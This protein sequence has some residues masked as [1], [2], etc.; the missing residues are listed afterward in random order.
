MPPEPAA[1]PAVAV[2]DSAAPAAEAPVVEPPVLAAPVPA[3]PPAPQLPAEPP[4]A[5]VAEP[6]PA[7]APAPAPQPPMAVAAVPPLAVTPPAPIAAPDVIPDAFV[8]EASRTAEGSLRLS[9]SVPDEATRVALADLAAVDGLTLRPDLPGDFAAGAQAGLAALGRIVEGR[10]GFADGVWAL[11][12]EAA[13]SADRYALLAELGTA[14]GA[15]WRTDITV[16]PPVDFCRLR[17]GA[18]AGRNAILFRS[19]S[20]ELTDTSLPAL[21]ELAG[22]LKECP[23]ASIHVEGHTD[24]DGPE[25]LNLALSVARAES[26]V[27]ALMDRGVAL[28]R[29][30]AMGYGESLPVADNDTAAGKQRNRRI[31]F[32][33]IDGPQ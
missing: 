28:D 14:P 12:G 29:L 22:Y 9:G 18:F 23:Q 26:V 20:D 19:G 24:S 7:V 27:F 1:G 25:D 2:A 32:Q 4:P 17:V 21:D 11:Q 16:M 6:A 5:P 33:I 30:Y 3:I 15:R 31:A 13:T 8:F 10:I